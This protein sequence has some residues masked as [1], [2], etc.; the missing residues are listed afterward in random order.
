MREYSKRNPSWLHIFDEILENL[1]SEPN[2]IHINKTCGV[3]KTAVAFLQRDKPLSEKM[4]N[5]IRFNVSHR[6][7]LKLN[8]T[9]VIFLTLNQRRRAKR[10]KIFEMLI[11]KINELETQNKQ[12]EES[13]GFSSESI[14]S[15]LKKHK[16]K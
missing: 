8:H 15:M 4:M 9:G 16:D 13:M 12:S 1:K 11:A 14:A 6:T 7:S 2:K 3:F 10:E 5:A